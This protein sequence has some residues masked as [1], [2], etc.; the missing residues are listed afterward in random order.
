MSVK[1]VEILQP[2]ALAL[3]FAQLVIEQ[4]EKAIKG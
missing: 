2:V 1:P 3:H 4:Q